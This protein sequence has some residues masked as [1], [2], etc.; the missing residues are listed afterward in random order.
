MS[1]SDPTVRGKNLILS[2]FTIV[3]VNFGQFKGIEL[4]KSHSG[5][6]QINPRWTWTIAVLYF[7]QA[8]FR[9]H[10]A[11]WKFGI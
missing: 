3:G 2:H 4:G 11:S 7:G 9:L 10:F 1:I 8:K 6:L 5:I